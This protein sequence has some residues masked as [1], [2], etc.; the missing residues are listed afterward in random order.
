MKR[1]YLVIFSLV[2]AASCS[3]T[4]NVAQGPANSGSSLSP[5]AERPQSVTAHTT[6]NRAL[7]PAAPDPAASPGKWSAGGDPIDTAKFDG[8]IAEAEKIVKSKPDD[9]QAKKVLSEAYFDRADALTKARQYAAALGDYRRALKYDPENKEAKEWIDQIISI[10][11][12][13]KKEGP[14]EGEE[15]P[16]L[17]FK[18]S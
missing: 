13:L 8:T 15:P 3:N 14:K 10:Y 12:M 5:N 9:V 16:P 6:E 4:G 1:I 17:P 18:K 11:Q 7:E 2:A